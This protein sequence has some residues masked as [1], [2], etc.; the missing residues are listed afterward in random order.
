MAIGILILPILILAALALGVLV[1]YICY[2]A[3][4]NSKLRTEESG[5]HVP[6]ASMESV[7]K[8]VVII[9]AV[10]MYCSLNSKIVNLQDELTDT[11]ITLTD[12]I[13]EMQY[14]LY[15]M[16]ETMKKE[17]SMIS[18]VYYDFGEINNKEHT[19]EMKF[20]VVP[21]KYSAE[22][23]MSLNYRGQTIMFTNNGDGSFT[24]SAVFPM[25]DE[26]Y[27]DGLFCITEGGVTKTERWED[28]VWGALKDSCLPE[29]YI[30]E[31]SF[32]YERGNGKNKGTVTVK[33][34]V[35]LRSK[36]DVTGSFRNLKLIV[37]KNEAIIDEITAESDSFV[38]ERSYPITQGEKLSVWLTGEDMYGY[39][40]EQHL[41][42]WRMESGFSAAEYEMMPIEVDRVTKPEG[43]LSTQ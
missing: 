27:E 24:G 32:R 36:V 19:V 34:T 26:V 3:A 8:V 14:D 18:A 9:G 22:T 42:G 10:V 40:H 21:N 16:Q 15:E 38:I 6:M 17:T 13:A 37:K 25:F 28:T 41:S 5:A 2:K 20:R 11:K 4:I 29:F 7:L 33:G 31:S 35:S 39:T 23:E 30:A 1:Y 43:P 12:Q